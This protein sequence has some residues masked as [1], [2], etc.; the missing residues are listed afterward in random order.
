MQRLPLGIQT[1][2]QIIE[3]NM[4]YV[5]KTGFIK[6]LVDGYKYVFLSR[7]R[8]F[9]KSLFLSTL[10]EYFSGNKELF[11]GLDVYD[12]VPSVRFPVLRFDFSRLSSSTAANLNETLL[13]N[14]RGLAKEFS[15]DA[16]SEFIGDF[17][18]ELVRGISNSHN[19]RVVILIDEYDKPI[20]D[21]LDNPE[22]ATANREILREFYSV[23][24]S[25]DDQIEFMFVTGVSKFT[26]VSLFSGLNQITDITL[27]EK[28]AAVCGY[29][30]AELE[31]R[32][33]KFIKNTSS[34]IYL[35]EPELMEKIRFWYN[36]Y[37]WDGKTKLYNP[38]A[39]LN[40][41]SISR[42]RNYWW[43]TG[44][45]GYLL[46]LIKSGNYDITDF[47]NPEITES[48][49]QFEDLSR[50]DL[51]SLLFQ[52]GY[53]TISRIVLHYGMEKFYL[54]VPNYEVQNSLYSMLFADK[55]GKPLTDINQKS[56]DFL[57]YLDNLEIEKFRETLVYL[58]SQIPYQLHI[59]EEKYYHSLFIMIMHMAGINFQAEVSTP[60]GRI[61]GV[62]EF[63]NSVFVIEFKYNKPAV[64]GL[65]QILKKKYYEK[66]LS[67]GKKLYLLGAGITRNNIEVVCKEYSKL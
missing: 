53:L 17:L 9:G 12:D 48:T 67:G 14:L 4:L 15:I 39:I 63:P 6:P 61:D 62:I 1:F 3:Q 34:V 26:K 11:R 55:T 25:L 27:D 40:F 51:M 66:Y 41:F 50:P 45:P 5:D 57:Y 8:R 13:N 49:S 16:E 43:D 65:D 2:S 42:F 32:F 60:A 29:T 37:S 33:G 36:G 19:K 64:D 31:L 46:K 7:P 23:I 20:V 21:H 54:A 52:T 18:S 58:F 24:K 28:F 38:Y 59:P 47:S 30:Q 44:T 22:L 35:D 56:F 10:G